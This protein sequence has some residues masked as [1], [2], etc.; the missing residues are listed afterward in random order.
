MFRA[1]RML[2]AAL[3]GDTVTRFDLRVPQLATA[4][5]TGEQVHGVLPRGKHLLTRIGPW[6]LHS[7]LKM[8]GAWPV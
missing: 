5:L 6:T 2:N 1:A 3:A 7:H 8:E 4:D